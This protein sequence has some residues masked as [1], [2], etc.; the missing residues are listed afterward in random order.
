MLI[1]MS[2][3]RYV[4]N[5][6]STQFRKLDFQRSNVKVTLT[7]VHYKGRDCSES[8]IMVLGTMLILMS[9]LRYVENILSTKCM[10]T[11]YPPTTKCKLT[12]GTCDKGD[13]IGRF[14]ALW[15]T[16]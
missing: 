2:Q 8:E 13:Q 4:E 5:I 6:L 14:F 11:I 9:Q 1:L 15:A 16:F 3:H 10:K 12:L 7:I